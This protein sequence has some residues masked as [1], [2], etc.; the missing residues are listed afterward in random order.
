MCTLRR[1][2][3]VGVLGWL[4]TGCATVDVW[5]NRVVTG[6]VTDQAG[7]PVANSP[8]LVVA[9][10]LELSVLRYEYEE[11][12]RIE[13]KTFTNPEGRYRLEFVPARSGNNFYLF[14]FDASHFDGVKYKRP[15]PI[16]ITDRLKQADPVVVNQVLQFTPAW[17][18]V[19]RQIAYFGAESARGKILRSH[20][21]PDKREPS[22]EAGG[23]AE[24]WWYYSEGV[25][26]SFAGDALTRTSKFP[27]T[28]RAPA[29][30]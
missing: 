27:P 14:F 5:G 18:E 3:V 2:V 24:I 25:S 20:G 9:R 13:L 4:L 26:F 30:P 19:E 1:V 29:S 11:R 6:Q 7:T 16:E 21:L 10:N 15:E 28:L 12:G 8:V 23:D 22:P 17:P